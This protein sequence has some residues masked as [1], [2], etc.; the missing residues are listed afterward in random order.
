[1]SRRV[2]TVRPETPAHEAAAL[3]LEFRIGSLPVVSD[4]EQLIGV[5][6]ETEFHAVAERALRG[7]PLARR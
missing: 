7:E 5:I 3:L 2:R 4:E 6:T 1:M